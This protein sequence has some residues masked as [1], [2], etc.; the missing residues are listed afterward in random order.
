MSFQHFLRGF[1]FLLLWQANESY[2]QK[3]N[4]N[5]I[6]FI[7]PS[8]CSIEAKATQIQPGDFRHEMT[9]F[10][11]V[12]CS[13]DY[14]DGKSVRKCGIISKSGEFILP[15]IFKSISIL[16]GESN[17]AFVELNASHAIY[18]LNI[19]KIIDTYDRIIF[20]DDVSTYFIAMKSEEYF[21]LDKN[22]NKVLNL[23]D[24]EMYSIVKNDLII[25]KNKMTKLFG[26]YN[27]RLKKMIIEDKFTRIELPFMFNGLIV[28]D[29]RKKYLFDLEGKRV[30]NE[31]FLDFQHYHA[32]NICVIQTLSD[33]QN[34]IFSSG[35]EVGRELKDS[36]L[37]TVFKNFRGK[38]IT[39]KSYL[40]ENKFFS[41]NKDEYYVAMN[42]EGMYGVINSS[43]KVVIPFKY[44][45]IDISRTN[46][47]YGNFGKNCELFEID[48]KEIKSI[49]KVDNGRIFENICGFFISKDGLY[50][51]LD[52][53]LELSK[54][55]KG[56]KRFLH[57]K[58]LNTI[59][60]IQD[61]FDKWSFHSSGKDFKLHKYDNIS[62]YNDVTSNDFLPLN[63]VSVSL[64]GLWGL[65]DLKGIEVV[66]PI[67]DDIIRTDNMYILV[68][69]D[70]KFGIYTIY[71][72][73]AFGRDNDG[74][75]SKSYIF[76]PTYDFVMFVSPYKY[77]AEKD[78]EQFYLT[79]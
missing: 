41:A 77:Y 65:C 15:K 45:Y 2:A 1:I 60:V 49:L 7:K 19:R 48:G 14:I 74:I 16:K 75:K 36:L 18:D 61:K 62:A 52:P 13:D 11:Q 5:G 9:K 40:F 44:D 20:P 58:L 12:I 21:L 70:E 33:E 22:C 25:V 34:V 43:K 38:N 71:S 46:K 6:K 54:P 73:N 55:I 69:K 50:E 30:L 23:P 28:T 56:I 63:F 68:K 51:S 27:P 24:F 37:S 67:F 10:G 57:G 32:T 64:N 47:L 42:L 35:R 66:S 53:K 72:S 76:A 4:Y 3:E 31:L 79:F 29:Q 39:G 26:V 59:F 17:I 8:K 78:G